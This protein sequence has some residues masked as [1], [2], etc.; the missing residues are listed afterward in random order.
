MEIALLLQINANKPHEYTPYSHQA[1]IWRFFVKT[2]VVRF[3]W[4][5]FG[6]I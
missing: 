5:D 3:D 2:E 6:G 1:E 4:T